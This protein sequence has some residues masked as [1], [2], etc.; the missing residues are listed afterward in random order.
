MYFTTVKKIMGKKEADLNK[1]GPFLASCSD[2]CMYTC[3][4]I[5]LN[6]RQERNQS[7]SYNYT[8]IYIKLFWSH[9]LR[10]RSQSPQ[11]KK[12]LCKISSSIQKNSFPRSLHMA[13]LEV[14]PQWV[15]VCV[16]VYSIHI[17]TIMCVYIHINCN[18][19]LEITEISA[20]MKGMWKSKSL[21][22]FKWTY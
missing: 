12:G 17:Y 1:T 21:N 4:H 13:R 10:K 19:I 5:Y 9:T 6:K 15:S 22:L 16:C 20:T 8:Y 11:E 2:I 14:L 7:Y 3:T 18:M